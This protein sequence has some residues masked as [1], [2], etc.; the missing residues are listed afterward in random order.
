MEYYF[1][2]DRIKNLTFILP[3]IL[4]LNKNHK[5][6]VIYSLFDKMNKEE[7]IKLK[8]LSQINNFKKM[9]ITKVR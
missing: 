9:N 1:Y 3:L 6:I 2:I 8:T 7:E 4:K 5:I